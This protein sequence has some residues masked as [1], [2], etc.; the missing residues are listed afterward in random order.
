M[1][2]SLLKGHTPF[3]Q[4]LRSYSMFQVIYLVT[5]W[6]LVNSSYSRKVVIYIY[7]FS[8][9]K[10]RTTK[11][12]RCTQYWVLTWCVL[13]ILSP[14]WKVQQKPCPTTP[15]AVIIHRA[16]QYF[17]FSFFKPSAKRPIWS[18][19]H[20]DVCGANIIIIIIIMAMAHDLLCNSMI[21]NPMTCI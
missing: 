16:L 1:P 15:G 3:E 10:R 8:E 20:G 21:T 5:Q 17:R 9:P 11:N 18:A 13:C 7:N 14:P 2:P 19:T 4:Q 6:I 12:R